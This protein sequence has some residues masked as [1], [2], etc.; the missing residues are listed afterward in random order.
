MTWS[1]HN[2]IR[3]FAPPKI[4]VMPEQGLAANN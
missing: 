4:R 2:T 3:Y 1:S